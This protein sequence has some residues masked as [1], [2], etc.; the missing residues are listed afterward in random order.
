[1]AA[2]AELGSLDFMTRRFHYIVFLA[3]ALAGCDRQ[4]APQGAS[5]PS[6]VASPTNPVASMSDEQILGAIGYEPATLTS[7]RTDGKDGH[8]MGYSNE[9][10]LILV[11]RSLVSGVSVLRLRPEEQKQEWMLGKP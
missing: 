10:T 5:T 2:V 6:H 4:S 1:M 9:T 7:H 8:S 11:T 3:L